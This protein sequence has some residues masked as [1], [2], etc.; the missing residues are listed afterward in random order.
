[1]APKNI[2]PII[3][4]F[5]RASL[6]GR[7]FLQPCP[8]R[9]SGF[10]YVKLRGALVPGVRVGMEGDVAPAGGPG[11]AVSSSSL[12]PSAS[13]S[14]VPRRPRGVAPEGRAPQRRGP[15]IKEVGGGARRGR[16]GGWG[17]LFFCLTAVGFLRFSYN[18]QHGPTVAPKCCH[19]HRTHDPRPWTEPKKGFLSRYRP[20]LVAVH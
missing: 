7:R 18:D 3:M 20:F 11:P 9:R 2:A 8:G 16:V 15:L 5:A 1:M 6:K 4:L 14:T 12:F 13:S 10:N 17:C 19:R